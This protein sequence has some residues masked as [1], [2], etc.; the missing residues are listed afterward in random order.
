MNALLPLALGTDGDDVRFEDKDFV[1]RSTPTLL[2]SYITRLAGSLSFF[3]GLLLLLD[4]LDID[5]IFV[6][7]VSSSAG[8]VAVRTSGGLDD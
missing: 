8:G 2:L 1:P 3:D 7:R 5:L 6:F 4:E